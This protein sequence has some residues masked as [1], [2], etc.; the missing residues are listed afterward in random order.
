MGSSNTS[1][2]SYP[3]PIITEELL[4]IINLPHESLLEAYKTSTPLEYIDTNIEPHTH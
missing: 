3:I 4:Q 2:Q 1:E